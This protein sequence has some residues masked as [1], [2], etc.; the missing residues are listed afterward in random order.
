MIGEVLRV[1][2]D[3]E[4]GAH[5]TNVV[6][7]TGGGSNVTAEYF[8]APGDDSPPCVGDM[9]TLGES[10]GA[11][12]MAVTG[13][14]DARNAGKAEGGER[15]FYARDPD[16]VPV[17]EVWLKGDGTLE[18]TGIKCGWKIIG[19]SDGTVEINGATIDTSGNLKTPG[20]VSASGEVTAMAAGPGVKLSTHQ[21][22]T[23]VGPSGPPTPG[24]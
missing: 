16:G 2:R 11:G 5:V 10:E 23:G 12:S 21:H 17:S 9:V 24:T 20:E 8:P 18:M 6:V 13:A 22:P 14:N 15:R 1:E 4:E 19:K 7:D 3:T